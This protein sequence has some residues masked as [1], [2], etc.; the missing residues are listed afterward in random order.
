MTAALE[1]MT[2]A[3]MSAD[4]FIWA[5]AIRIGINDRI[6]FSS[7]CLVITGC[8]L[9]L[10]TTGVAV[11]TMFPPALQSTTAVLAS[12]VLIGIGLK[13]ATEADRSHRP[14]HRRLESWATIWLFGF[15]AGLDAFVVGLSRSGLGLDS[16]LLFLAV[17][18]STIAALVAGTRLRA[19]LLANVEAECQAIG[20]LALASLGV[21]SLVR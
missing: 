12:A 2:A 18:I 5:L 17:G 19:R 14:R 16:A 6:R 11:D 13:A 21:I 10:L 15:G 8:T 3:G 9:A 1:I 4:V 7:V 20:G